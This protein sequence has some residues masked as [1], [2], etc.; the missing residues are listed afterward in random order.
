MPD[1]LASYDYIFKHEPLIEEAVLD[2]ASNIEF[3]DSFLSTS[4]LEPVRLYQQLYLHRANVS[5][6]EYKAEFSGI[7]EFRE[8]VV[9]LRLIDSE[10]VNAVLPLR[11]WCFDQY[12]YVI[13]ENGS[14]ELESHTGPYDKSVQQY[15]DIYA[16]DGPD[17]D[18][19]KFFHNESAAR[20][21]Y[22]SLKS[23]SNSSDFG[24]ISRKQILDDA[25][26]FFFNPKGIRF[27]ILG[28]DEDSSSI[29]LQDLRNNNYGDDDSINFAVKLFYNGNTS[30]VNIEYVYQGG[31]WFCTN[32]EYDNSDVAYDILQNDLNYL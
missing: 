21:F 6:T 13:H 30:I 7:C 14:Y 18:R 9:D 5:G 31:E 26:A 16:E 27:R 1:E 4:A 8:W 24:I 23:Q 12:S 15:L 29:T 20:K 3:D 11:Y 28:V 19:V 17:G 2:I 22:R 32:N 10:I 25:K